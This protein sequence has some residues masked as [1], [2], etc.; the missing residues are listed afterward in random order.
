MRTMFRRSQAWLLT[1]VAGGGLFVLEGCDPTV[2]DTVLTGVS[3]ATSSLSATFIGAFFQSLMAEEETATT[4]R[5]IVE[6][7]P[8]I[9]A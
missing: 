3:S 9:F 2:R 7:A 8:E 6:Y 4:V 5:G 1:I